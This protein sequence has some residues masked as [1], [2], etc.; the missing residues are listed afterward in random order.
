MFFWVLIAVGAVVVAKSKN[1]VKDVP[2]MPLAVAIGLGAVG[3]GLQKF[4]SDTA[5]DSAL[6]VV[7]NNVQLQPDLEA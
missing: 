2:W 7:V 1:K 5:G 4:G 6:L 3:D